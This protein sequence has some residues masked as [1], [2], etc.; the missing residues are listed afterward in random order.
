MIEIINASKSATQKKRALQVDTRNTTR[1]GYKRLRAL[2]SQTWNY[3]PEMAKSIAS[4]LG[5]WEV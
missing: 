3:L 1:S 4:N 5:I 2:V